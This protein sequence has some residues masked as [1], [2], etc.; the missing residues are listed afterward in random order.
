MFQFFGDRLHLVDGEIFKVEPWTVL[1]KVERAL[2]PDEKDLF[3]IEKRFHKRDDGYYCVGYM[4]KYWVVK[5][6]NFPPSGP[7]LLCMPETK[8]RSKGEVIPDDIRR[9]LEEFYYPINRQ[10]GVDF[11]WLK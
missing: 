11:S 2:F 1:A 9:K 6:L 4:I 8:G 7:N 5:D 3:F 10:L